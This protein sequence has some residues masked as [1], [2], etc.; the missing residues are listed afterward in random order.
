MFSLDTELQ[1]QGICTAAA[2]LVL[3][4][5]LSAGYFMSEK[6]LGLF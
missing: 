4:G 5:M 6:S 1:G 2:R 3:E